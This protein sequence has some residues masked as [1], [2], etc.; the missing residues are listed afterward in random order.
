VVCTE[1]GVPVEGHSPVFDAFI[2]REVTGHPDE[3][4]GGFVVRGTPTD[5]NGRAYFNTPLF[6]I[7]RSDGTIIHLCPFDDLHECQNPPEPPAAS[8][9]GPMASVG[10]PFESGDLCKPYT[11][12]CE[13]TITLKGCTPPTSYTFCYGGPSWLCPAGFENDFIKVETSWD[14]DKQC[15]YCEGV[16][17]GETYIELSDFSAVGRLNNVMVKW[18]TAVEIENAGFNLYRA[19]SA[20]GSYVRIN[21]KL[22]PAKSNPISG[23]T[24]PY[25]DKDVE[26]GK[27]YFYKLEDVDLQGNT[28]MHGP[29]SATTRI[30][31]GL[32]K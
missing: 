7:P 31:R 28:M 19:D 17:E 3:E 12:C 30:I 4:L 2:M 18:T 16:C 22:I 27:T 21:P 23:R 29:V 24:Y 15:N 20:D 26:R 10:L 9:G 32:F 14:V 25:L 13:V 8:F 6:H 11:G 1:D 5:Q